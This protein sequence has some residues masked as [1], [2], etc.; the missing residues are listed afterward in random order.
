MDNVDIVVAGGVVAAFAAVGEVV[1]GGVVEG[2]AGFVTDGGV[3]THTS[4]GRVELSD[5]I[6]E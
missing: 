6:Q 1:V 3:V 2:D 4:E 5:Y